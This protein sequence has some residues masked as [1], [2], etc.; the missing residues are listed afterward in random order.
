VYIREEA[1]HHIGSIL[2]LIALVLYSIMDDG[3]TIDDWAF[4]FFKL[5]ILKFRIAL[6]SL[7]I[8]TVF[9]R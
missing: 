7:K 3:A 4:V 5:D 1:E 6:H 9:L 2:A 8:P